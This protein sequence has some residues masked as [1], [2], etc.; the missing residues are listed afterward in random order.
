MKSLVV[1]IVYLLADRLHDHT[2]ILEKGKNGL[3]CLLAH[4]NESGLKI[5]TKE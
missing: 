5:V 1:R 2:K 4:L 3:C